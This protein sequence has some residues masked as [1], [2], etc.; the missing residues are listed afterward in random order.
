MAAAE[1][2]E[3][4]AHETSGARARVS[5]A[6]KA[7]ALLAAAAAIAAVGIG[8]FGIGPSERASRE[9]EDVGPPIDRRNT[10]HAPPPVEPPSAPAPGAERTSVGEPERDSE[11]E[12][13]ES[14]PTSGSLR[15]VVVRKDGK[16]LEEECVVAIGP[17]G[18]PVEGAAR[19]TSRATIPPGRDRCAF[20]PLPFGM[21]AVSAVAES[22][23]TGWAQVFVTPEA[24]HPLV[25]LVL[26]PARF[27]DGT[28][29]DEEGAPVEGVRVSIV[30]EDEEAGRI[31]AEARSNA[32]GYYRIEGVVE[33]AYSLRVGPEESAF[34]PPVRI[35]IAA[36]ALRH[37]V[38][39]ASLG[40]LEVLVTDE[41]GRPLESALVEG[42]GPPG[43][44][45]RGRTEPTGAFVARALPAGEY[46]VHVRYEGLAPVF[47][48][49]RVK[50]GER[51]MHRA[52]LRPI[53]P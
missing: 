13:E 16:P 48:E 23:T 38:R 36:S 19:T 30:P 33:G 43:G 51:G 52:V 9:R 22:R 2:E 3:R 5:N 18:L 8:L 27:V 46:R 28:I 47:G 31:R 12:I 35:S 39:L 29:L 37:D 32:A 11:I 44:T 15:V 6:R 53:P 20:D 45:F 17:P 24:P 4:P 41:E 26:S 7:L 49:T 14:A 10:T 50:A 40:S 21:Y 25:R 1:P 42:Y 34:F